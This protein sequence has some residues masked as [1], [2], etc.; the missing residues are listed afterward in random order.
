MVQQQVDECHLTPV[1]QYSI[2]QAG[3]QAAG[4]SLVTDWTCVVEVGLSTGLE[5]QPETGEVVVGS[6]DVE[7]THHEGVEGAGTQ[8]QTGTQL[9][10]HV[11]ISMKPEE[12]MDKPKVLQWTLMIYDDIC[13]RQK[14]RFFSSS[15]VPL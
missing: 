10:V 13:L 9:V 6:T 3:G 15:Q 14:Q 12:G 8:E 2:Q 4:Q 5:Q 7:R 11:Y 1:S